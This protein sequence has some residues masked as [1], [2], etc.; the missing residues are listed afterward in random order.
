MTD[1]T[2]TEPAAPVAPA[3][4]APPAAPS[5]PPRPS[6]ALPLAFAATLLVG[7]LAGAGI[8]WITYD[9]DGS[10]GRHEYPGFEHRQMGPPQ[11]RGPGGG[12]GG[13]GGTGGSGDR[14]GERLPRG[15]QGGPQQGG[16]S[17]G[18]SQ[19]LLPNQ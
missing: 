4:P 6:L 19:P 18:D 1:P 7:V 17:S 10:G 2:P 5:P 8:T 13:R 14:N 12:S 11:F 9:R 15:P 16:P 3:P